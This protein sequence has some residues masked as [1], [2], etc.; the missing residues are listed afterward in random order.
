MGAEFMKKKITI[1]F[2]VV[3]IL[4]GIIYVS[5]FFMADQALMYEGQ[6]PEN[7]GAYYLTDSIEGEDALQYAARSFGRDLPVEEVY[8]L[9]F[10]TRGDSFA[11]VHLL[12]SEDQGVLQGL[13]DEKVELIEG[14]DNFTNIVEKEFNDTIVAYTSGNERD[15]YFFISGDRYVWVETFEETRNRFI[16]NAIRIF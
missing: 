3:A 5:T 1:S 10:Q 8:V 11:I 13:L 14:N 15:H 7:I 12:I 16:R 6:V 2:S 9:E 4:A